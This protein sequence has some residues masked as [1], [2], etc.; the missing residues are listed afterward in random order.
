M[1][2]YSIGI[3]PC[4]KKQKQVHRCAQFRGNFP[5]AANKTQPFL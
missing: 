5:E 4:I 3:F 2:I 1:C